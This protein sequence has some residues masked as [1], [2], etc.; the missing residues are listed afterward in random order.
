MRRGGTSV[1]ACELRCWR[2]LFG[3][4]I[5]I[6]L[7]Y[8]SLYRALQL[9][10]TLLDNA[11]RGGTG[12]IAIQCRLGKDRTGVLI[13]LSQS[14][15]SHL[16]LLISSVTS[17]LVPIFLITSSLKN[18]IFITSFRKQLL[19]TLL[20][21]AGWGCAGGIA[22]QCRLGKDRTGV[23]TLSPS[24]YSPLAVLCAI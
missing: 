2:W 5:P 18:D 13:T 8:Q 19:I 15:W 16:C 12:S 9:L 17:R 20:D 23:F 3:N 1:R 7:R 4:N 10:I 11:G 22:I 24:V 14:A 6:Y 21:N